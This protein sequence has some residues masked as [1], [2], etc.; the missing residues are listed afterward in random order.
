MLPFL[1]FGDSHKENM[2]LPSLHSAFSTDLGTM[3]PAGDP[4]LV[5]KSPVVVA[6]CCPPLPGPSASLCAAPSFLLTLSS[7]C[8]HFLL[9][10]P[11]V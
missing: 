10:F 6:F 1:P 9:A 5:P 11:V 4:A 2:C 8:G 7:S 3:P